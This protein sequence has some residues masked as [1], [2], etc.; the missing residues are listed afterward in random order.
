MRNNLDE[1]D[2]QS[3]VKD[4]GLIVM[5]FVLGYAMISNPH[6]FDDV[7]ATGRRFLIK[8]IFSYIWGIPVGVM[9]I[10]GGLFFSY[11][12]YADYVRKK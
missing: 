1:I 9:A 2:W 11:R 5:L 3:L 7:H 6:M 12:F 4:L 10:G 8:I